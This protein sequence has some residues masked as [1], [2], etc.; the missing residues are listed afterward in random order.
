MFGDR[1]TETDWQLF[2]TLVRFDTVY[3]PLFRCNQRRIADYRR[4]SACL[5]RLY[6]I[7]GVAET[8]QFDHIKRHYFDDLGLID[9][10]T[11][12]KGPALDRGL[13][14]GPV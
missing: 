12:P 3:Y 14:V 11:V 2:S 6:D 1:L 7:P 4:L 9:P 8:V 5:R 13:P 10:A